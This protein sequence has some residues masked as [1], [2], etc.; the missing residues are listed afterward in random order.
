MFAS[1]AEIT[2]GG[3]RQPHVLVEI[4]QKPSCSPA[5]TRSQA[6]A[7]F[8]WERMGPRLSRTH[9]HASA[10]LVTCPIRK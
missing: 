7:P 5:A 6:A 9:E 10:I 2:Q 3:M 1:T 4:R 8:R